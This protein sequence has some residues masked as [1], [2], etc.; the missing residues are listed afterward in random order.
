[1]KLL[2]V[3][4]FFSVT[5]AAHAVC[6]DDGVSDPTGTNRI[7]ELYA[8]AIPLSGPPSNLTG[9]E[10]NLWPYLDELL[11]NTRGD[12]AAKKVLSHF[13][14]NLD[15]NLDKEELDKG[16]S[17]PPFEFGR[18]GR[19]LGIPV[20]LNTYGINGLINIH[21]TKRFVRRYGF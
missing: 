14:E 5:L 11:G 2:A 9:Q 7:D 10:Q 17:K 20:L 16:F 12:E 19:S 3:V 15:G 18:L 21:G 4:M 8:D 1:M 6:V 13:D